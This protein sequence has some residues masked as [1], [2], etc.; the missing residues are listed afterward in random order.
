VAFYASVLRS[1]MREGIFLA[2]GRGVVKVAGIGDAVPG[3]G[4][5]SEFAGHPIPA[6]NDSDKVAFGAAV[7]GARTTEGVFARAR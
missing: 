5:L 6:L 3:A 7:A 2:T 1:K 4:S